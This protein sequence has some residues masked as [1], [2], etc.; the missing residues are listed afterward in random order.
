MT[1]QIDAVAAT[2]LRRQIPPTVDARGLPVH[3]SQNALEATGFVLQLLLLPRHLCLES[4]YP[5][6]QSCHLARLISNSNNRD[7]GD[8]GDLIRRL[9][10]LA[11]QLITLP[12]QLDAFVLAF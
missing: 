11:T 4:P 1:H 7:Q 2:L 8:L 9:E 6:G 10:Q 12:A 5:G 3:H